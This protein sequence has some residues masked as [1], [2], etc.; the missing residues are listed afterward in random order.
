MR[1]ANNLL[2]RIADMDNLRLAFWKAAQG[3]RHAA[4]V[5]AYQE[6]LEANL[7]ELRDQIQ[8]ANV[9]V[10]DYRYFTIYEPK[11]R[12]ICAAAFGEQVLHH[13]LMN[14]CHE[15]F[16]RRLIFDTYACREGK[17]TYAALDRARQNT[18][19]YT[20]FLKLD[21]KQFFASIH[22]DVLKGQLVRLFKEQDLLAI[23]YQII[24]SYAATEDRGLPIGNL[25][26]QYFA[27]HHLSD[28][29]YFVKQELGCRAYVRYMD[30][31]VLWSDDKS[32]LLL[33]CRE[34]RQFVEDRLRM[35]LKPAQLN[36]ARLGL[37][38]LGYRIFPY[39]V[40]LLQKSKIRFARKMRRIYTQLEAGTWDE[41]AAQA[42]AL[43]LIAFTEHA[44]AKSFR[45]VVLYQL[46]GRTP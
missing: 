8:R 28:L 43:P 26:S 19:R 20:W 35:Q 7:R 36:R 16:D 29:D 11:E 45:K 1:K 2:P 18:K 44:A 31:L 17:G 10:G 32:A 40:R 12:Q 22:H 30:D 38:F 13:A 24:D 15:P 34:I 37:P 25:T 41:T 27:N 14:V 5:L 42:H 4:S 23:F 21:V 39:H 33:A 3:K 9:T 46:E 6:R